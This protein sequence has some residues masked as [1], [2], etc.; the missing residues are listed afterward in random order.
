MPD[1]CS[2]LERGNGSRR[3][4]LD[5]TSP[6]R[7]AIPS[8]SH[9][10]RSSHSPGKKNLK[11][12]CKMKRFMREMFLMTPA[13]EKPRLSIRDVAKR[14]NC[15]LGS[16][17][18]VLN[19]SLEVSPAMKKRVLKAM[20]DMGYVP[21][22]HARNLKSGRTYRLGLLMP[23]A[24]DLYYATLLDA[25]NETV[26]ETNYR[27]DVQ[28]HRWIE[29]EEDVA[30]RYFVES[31]MEG[32]ILHPCRTNYEN[33]ANIRLLEQYR[34]PCVVM[35]PQGI[36]NLPDTV[37]RGMQDLASGME[38]L[39]KHL[40]S[41][42]H[43]KIA[44]LLPA[45]SSKQLGMHERLDG[46]KR[47]VASYQGVKLEVIYMRAGSDN[48]PS[49]KDFKTYGI[50]ITDYQDYVSKLVKKFLSQKKGVTAAITVNEITAWMLITALKEGGFRVPEDFS[51]ATLGL[52]N[53]EHFGG[54]P[55][56]M[57]EYSPMDIAQCALDALLK[58]I[59]PTL[60]PPS[61]VVRRSSAPVC[62]SSP[63]Q[64]EEPQ[65]NNKHERQQ[66]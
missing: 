24:S 2:P 58:K 39:V 4:R 57:A 9:P 52:S 35:G 15:A 25:F 34:I 33:V 49:Q 51:V 16:A 5:A 19:G 46:A 48:V 10:S 17:S 59:E 47:G 50:S 22:R 8:D 29:K 13:L 20:E 45:S 21:N 37:F 62:F 43:R 64:P 61:L 30:I 31:G 56:T 66:T 42:G 23:F 40:A 28:L 63:G 41:L 38:L 7:T 53:T 12:T 55:L 14:A 44:L 65:N 11:N 27:L 6:A 1:T 3:T 60:V 18:K 26:M 36:C 54:F 32:V